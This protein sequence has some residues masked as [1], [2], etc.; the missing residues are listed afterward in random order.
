MTEPS[1][2]GPSRWHHRRR[3]R[4]RALQALY[5]CEVARLTVG[6]ALE[7]IE[8]AGAPEAAELPEDERAFAAGL[9]AGAWEARQALDERIGEAARNWRIERMAAID[10]LVLR[11]AVHEMLAHPETPPR[12]AI[13]EAIDIA[14]EF[15][16]E[17]SARF[18]NGVLDGVF[19]RLKHEGKIID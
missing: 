1:S 16:G 14:R 6:Q 5:Q 17:D 12:V 18:V 15:G 11:L 7:V 19:R 13:S 3:A 4:E 2:E 9:A 8:Q 10:R